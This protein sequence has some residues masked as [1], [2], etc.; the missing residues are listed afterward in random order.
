[1]KKAV[2][3]SRNGRL[4]DYTRFLSHT[5]PNWVLLCFT[6]WSFMMWH[7]YAHG[8]SVSAR[9]L[10]TWRTAVM[11]PKSRRCRKPLRR[12]KRPVET[13]IIWWMLLASTSEQAL[14]LM[15]CNIYDVVMNTWRLTCSVC[16]FR[17]ALL[18]RTKPEDMVDL[19]HTNLLGTMLT[20]R[21]ALRSM[22]H[23]QGAAIVNIGTYTQNTAIS[24]IKTTDWIRPA[25]SV[26][27]AKIS[28]WPLDGSL[29]HC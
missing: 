10:T 4:S 17:D 8:P 26:I 29:C 16:L 14:L 24:P 13:S 3:I 19:L 25:A 22:L 20:C 11:S 1:M 12:S 27:S 28:V 5:V 18:L 9:Q 6:V 15:D 23:T 21:A 7:L 2:N